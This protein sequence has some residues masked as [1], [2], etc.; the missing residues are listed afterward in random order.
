LSGLGARAGVDSVWEQEKP[1][2]T[3]REMFNAQRAAEFLAS[4]ISNE[5]V[6]NPKYSV[7]VLNG[8]YLVYQ[9]RKT[10]FLNLN[11][12]KNYRI[13]LVDAFPF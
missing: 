10:A 6:I 9:K 11:L 7:N 4:S 12:D 8:F 13:I 5:P 3:L 1:E 2:A